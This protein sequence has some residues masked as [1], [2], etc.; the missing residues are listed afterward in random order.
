MNTLRNQVQLI[1]N[2]AADLE[3]VTTKSDVSLVKFAM[4]TNEYYTTSKGEKVKET[5]WHR[6]VAWGKTAE[7]MCNLLKKGSE[8][9]I[10]G[11]LTYNSYDDKEGVRRYIT[12]IKATEFIKMD[13]A[14]AIEKEE[15]PF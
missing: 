15:A 2:I 8:V 1:G 5:Q 10:T 3:L 6:I 14:V 7:L 12:E 13:K 11:K 4:A 9:L